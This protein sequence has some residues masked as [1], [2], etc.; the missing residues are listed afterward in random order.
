MVSATVSTRRDGCPQL[1]IVDPSAA[2]IDVDDTRHRL[3]QVH[4][5]AP[6]E[7]SV[8]SVTADLVGID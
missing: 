5:H 2:W 8:G 1:D 7:H 4:W 6:A 3:L